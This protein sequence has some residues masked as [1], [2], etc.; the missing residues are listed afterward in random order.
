MFTV[1]LLTNA[2]GR[3]SNVLQLINDQQKVV[4]IYTGILFSYK[5]EWSTDTHYNM[6]ESLKHYAK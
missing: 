3:N 2:K 5:K 6:D 4:Q 1:A